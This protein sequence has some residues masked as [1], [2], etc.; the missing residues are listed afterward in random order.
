MDSASSTLTDSGSTSASVGTS[1][2]NKC[3]C[4]NRYCEK[5]GHHKAGGCVGQATGLDKV[6]YVGDVCRFCLRNFE[7]RFITHINGHEIRDGRLV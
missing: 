5:I 4:E 7:P 1:T 6:M 3:N 2:S